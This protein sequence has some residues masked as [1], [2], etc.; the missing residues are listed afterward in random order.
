MKR[1]FRLFFERFFR[2]DGI[3]MEQMF[4]RDI[5]IELDKYL[6]L[7][8]DFSFETKAIRLLKAKYFLQTEILRK[9]NFTETTFEMM[10]NWTFQF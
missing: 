1:Q 7:T 9:I 3:Q 5:V 4:G 8:T 6:S 10:S 2:D